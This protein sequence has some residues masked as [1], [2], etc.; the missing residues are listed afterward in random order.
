MCACLNTGENNSYVY[1]I[2]YPASTVELTAEVGGEIKS[3]KKLLQY[4]TVQYNAVV[5]ENTLWASVMNLLVY[6][7]ELVGLVKT[8]LIIDMFS[9]KGWIVVEYG[10]AC[11]W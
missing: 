1:K 4:S 5:M 7:Q 10:T 3:T 11:T 6:I 8:L 9:L 2:L